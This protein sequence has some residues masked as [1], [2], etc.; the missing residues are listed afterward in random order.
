MK[1]LFKHCRQVNCSYFKH[2]KLSLYL[3]Q[4]F[5]IASTKALIHGIIPSLYLTSSQDY[6]KKIQN[7]LDKSTCKK[8]MK[9]KK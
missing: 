9:L 1:Y 3:S 2:L 4:Q 7:I 6:S 5:S 8:N